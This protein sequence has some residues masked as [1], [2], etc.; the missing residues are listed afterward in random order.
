[1]PVYDYRFVS[2]GKIIKINQNINAIPFKVYVHPDT[3]RISA[4]E[5]LVSNGNFVLK[6][7]NWEKKKGY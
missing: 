4:V 2:D 3:G 7:E 1:M 5:R 6:G